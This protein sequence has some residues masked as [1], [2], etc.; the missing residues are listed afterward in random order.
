M[1]EFDKDVILL[2]LFIIMLLIIMTSSLLPW[3]GNGYLY[4]KESGRKCQDSLLKTN[5]RPIEFL[6]SEEIEI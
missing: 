4:L 1:N 3:M 6:R 2:L 5:L